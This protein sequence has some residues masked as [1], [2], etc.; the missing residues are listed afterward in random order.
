MGGAVL[1]KIHC[2]LWLIASQVI[3]SD[4]G[5]AQ[6]VLDI[7]G[8]PAETISEATKAHLRQTVPSIVNAPSTNIEEAAK[9]IRTEIYVN[10]SRSDVARELHYFNYLSCVVIFSDRN[11]TADERLVRIKTLRSVFVLNA[12][13]LRPPETR[14]LNPEKHGTLFDPMARDG[15]IARYSLGYAPYII[16][17]RIVL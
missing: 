13:E 11:M 3:W 6:T 4:R 9:T 7:C 14:P 15:F 16:D 12:P 1:K 5:V 17:S 10:S 8:S 2:V